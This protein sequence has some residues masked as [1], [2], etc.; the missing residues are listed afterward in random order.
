MNVHRLIS[1]REQLEARIPPKVVRQ[2][3]VWTPGSPSK[4]KVSE[5][6][7]RVWTLYNEFDPK[8]KPH[9]PFHPVHNSN[10]FME[11]HVHDWLW[12]NGVLSYH[13]RVIDKSDGCWLLI[14]FADENPFTRSRLP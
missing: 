11:D 8:K 5:Y 1:I 6:P 14:E 12:S 10:A 3:V 13:S 9:L 2:E 4:V 7:Y